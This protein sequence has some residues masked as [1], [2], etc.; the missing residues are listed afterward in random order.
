MADL[1]IGEVARRS[2]LRA[3]AIRYY[4]KIGLLPR[5]PR[6]GYQRRYDPVILDRLAIV[7]FAQYV[8]LRLTEIKWLLN[9]VPGRP[10]PERWRKLAKERLR[11]VDALIADAQAIRGLLQMTL[12]HKCPK[13]VER[14]F[15]LP[16]Q[17]KGERR[18]F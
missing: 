16:W 3:S 2:G 8:G 11:Q 18:G 7:R 4:E 13:L 15:S 12:D 6:T 9:D 17:L 10:P 5:V 14:G 1:S